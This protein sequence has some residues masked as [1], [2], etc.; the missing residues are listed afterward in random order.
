MKQYVTNKV[1]DCLVC[2]N[3]SLSTALAEQRFE[4]AFPLQALKQ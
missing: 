4:V 1:C 2:E 3:P